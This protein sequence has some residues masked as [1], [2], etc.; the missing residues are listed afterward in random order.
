MN[1][2]RRVGS[3]SRHFSAHQKHK[4]TPHKKPPN[5]VKDWMAWL[6]LRGD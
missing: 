5:P 2:L 1:P 4:K 3:K 6:E